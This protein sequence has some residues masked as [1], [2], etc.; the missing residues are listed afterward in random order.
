[1]EFRRRAVRAETRAGL[2]PG[3]FNPP[4]RAHL[5]MAEAALN[6]VEEVV[7]VLPRRFPHKDYSGPGLDD[8]L[9]MLDRA[10]AHEPRFSVA[11]NEGGL[12]IELARAFRSSGERARPVILCG[13]DAA[14]RA[15]GWSYED[16]LEFTTQ[17]Q[18]YDLL[19]APRHG[20]VLDVPAHLQTYVHHLA[21]PREWQDISSTEVRRRAACGED[22][23][24]LVPED[25]AAAV[26]RYYSSR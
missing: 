18:E 24:A 1:M 19:V 11:V 2:F 16:G 14:E 12:F 23:R 13:R 4:T 9:A 6:E 15:I 21:L 22:W 26:A 20:I 5:A 3:A 8:R 17:L 10:V 7:F 25:L